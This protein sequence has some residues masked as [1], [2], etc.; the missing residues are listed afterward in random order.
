MVRRIYDID[1]MKDNDDSRIDKIVVVPAHLDTFHNKTDVSAQP[2]FRL[3][4]LFEE[5]AEYDRLWRLPFHSL[6]F[7][8]EEDADDP[9][10]RPSRL[11]RRSPSGRSARQSSSCGWRPTPKHCAISATRLAPGRRSVIWPVA[12]VFPKRASRAFSAPSS[13]WRPSSGR[14]ADHAVADRVHGVLALLMHW[15]DNCRKTIYTVLHENNIGN[16]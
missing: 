4:A 14:S 5:R 13:A 11:R 1:D 2:T 9:G 8:A 16:S 3:V 6:A 15:L 7:C 10:P 12:W